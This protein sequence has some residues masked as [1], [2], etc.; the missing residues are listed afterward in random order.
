MFRGLVKL[1]AKFTQNPKVVT[2][3]WWIGDFPP[4]SL[5]FARVQPL[6]TDGA[7]VGWIP[8]PPQLFFT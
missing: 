7:L 6:F 4:M 2:G 1:Q 8:A 5:K 3:D